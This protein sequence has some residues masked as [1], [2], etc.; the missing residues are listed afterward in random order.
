MKKCLCFSFVVFSALAVAMVCWYNHRQCERVR[1]EYDELKSKYKKLLY[2]KYVQPSLNKTGCDEK[3]NEIADLFR[4]I[5]HAYENER[6]D[7]MREYISLMPADYCAMSADARKIAEAP[8]DFKKKFLWCENLRSFDK[9]DDFERF[10]RI[11]IEAAIFEGEMEVIMRDGFGVVQERGMLKRLFQY[12]EMFSKE[13]KSDLEASAERFISYWISFIE[14]DNGFSRRWARFIVE[15]NELI[16][17]IR[18]EDA[19]SQEELFRSVRSAMSGFKRCG[20]EPKWMKEFENP[21]R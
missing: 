1:E 6:I 21:P 4:K 20:Y 8:F 3:K 9:V 17:F 18:P 11:N 15:Y 10:I 19:K 14:S 13:G 2:E 5:A 16:K 7:S 12:K